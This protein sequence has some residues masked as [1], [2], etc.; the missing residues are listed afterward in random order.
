MGLFGTL[1]FHLNLSYS[2]IEKRDRP[3]VVR[4]C[5]SPL[6]TL[7]EELEWCPIAIEASAH[8]LERIA[9]IDPAWIARLRAAIDGGRVEFIGAGDT[10]L[11]G[12]LVPASVNR[13]N[14]ALGQESYQR[15]LGRRPRTAL[16]NEMAWSQGIIDHYLDA[17]YDLLLMEWN[18]PRRRHPEWKNDW[19]YRLSWSETPAGRRIAVGWIDAVAFQ[20]F[21]RAVVEDMEIDEYVAWVTEHAG[22][23]PRHLFLYASDAEVFDFRP[24]RFEVEAPLGEAGEWRRVHRIVEALHDAG[25]EFTTPGRLTDPDLR[26][27]RTLCL[28]SASDPIPVKKQPKYNV[29]RWGLSGWD[30]VGLNTRCHA[31]AAELEREGGD[32]AAWRALCR[33]WASDRRTH[34]TEAR[35]DEVRAKCEPLVAAPPPEVGD[36]LRTARTERR[37]KLL[38]VETDDVR[39]V[40]NLRRGLALD[41]LAFPSMSEEGVIGTLPHGHFDD[42][43]WAA[44]F[45][46]GHTVLEM[47]ATRR[48]TDL[49]RVEP[50]IE[51]LADRIVVAARVPTPLGPLP[52]RVTVRAREIELFYGLSQLGERPLGSVRTAFLTLLPGVVDD[53]FAITAANGGARETFIVREECDHG[54]SVSPLVSASAAFG[55]TDGRLRIEDG[56][57]GFD[58]IWDPGE[59]AALPLLTF[60]RIGGQHFVRIAFSL[61]EVDETHRPSAPLYDF[62]LTIRATRNHR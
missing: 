57:V 3:E 44:D 1:L 56:G 12:P 23:R 31:R 43:D 25:I 24:G 19:R 7:A 2:A 16:V 61:S 28:R 35:W 34:L 26:P 47:P 32:A 29:I 36:A 42:I 14:Q 9:E 54:A 48:V 4:R 59:A 8:T 33:D 37:G 46:S 51:R 45:Y 40:L 58:V 39:V 53:H 38:E 13:W 10:Q 20:K 21:Q 30:D 22:P 17:D 15:I 41:S 60:R 18:N 62:R 55:A 52:K 6:L 49:E 27:A 11:I 50:T 5:Y